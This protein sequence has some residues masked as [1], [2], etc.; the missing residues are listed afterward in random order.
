MTR[1]P[2]TGVSTVTARTGVITIILAPAKLK[3]RVDFLED[4][5]PVK[6]GST[7]PAKNVEFLSQ[8]AK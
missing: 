6:G 2:I 7:P 3:T 1:G 5:S 4:M 8:N